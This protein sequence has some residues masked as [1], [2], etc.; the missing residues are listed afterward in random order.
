V[1]VCVEG[2]SV[3]SAL[4]IFWKLDSNTL[5]FIMTLRI[6]R[7]ARLFVRIEQFKVEGSCSRLNGWGVVLMFLKALAQPQCWAVRLVGREGRCIIEVCSPSW[8]DCVEATDHR[9]AWSVCLGQVI[10]STFKHILPAVGQN[11]TVGDGPL[12]SW[13]AWRGM[14]VERKPAPICAS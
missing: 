3:V 6:L 14:Q 8:E 1:V 4:P 7:V 11:F 10:G 2:R 12:P 13:W 9:T 5:R